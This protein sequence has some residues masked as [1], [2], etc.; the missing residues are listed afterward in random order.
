[1]RFNQSGDLFPEDASQWW[2]TDGDSYGDNSSSLIGDSCPLVNGASYFDRYGCE[3]SD[4]D[5]WSDPTLD[6]FAPSGL[7]DAFPNDSTQWKDTDGD[8]YGDNLTGLS[9]DLCPSTNPLYQ[10]YL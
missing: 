10:A 1:M 3:D 6:W 7:A 8:S 9:P 5:G 2:D 4:S